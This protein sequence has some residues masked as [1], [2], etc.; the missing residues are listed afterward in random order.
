MKA[1]KVLLGAA[2]YLVAAQLLAGEAVFYITEEGSAVRD[3]AVSVN[4]QKKLVGAS[5]FVSFD[6]AAGNYRVELSKY[7]EYLGEFDFS[8]NSASEHA[9]IQVELVGGEPMPDINLY[10]P[11]QETAPAL[12][13]L[14]GFI[15]SAETGGGVAG[16]S[17]VVSGTETAVV[18]DSEGYFSLELPR[19]DYAL[20]IAHPNYGKRD[21][22]SV[23]VMGNVN[24]GL[25][26]TLSMSGDGM[27]EEVV[28]VGSYIPSTATAQQRDSS[29]VLN[30]IGAEQL[31]RFGDS[32]AASALK[33]VAG[34]S[35]VGGQFA[36]VRGM[37]GRYI[38]STLNG[39]LMPSTDPM[40]RDVPLD[41]F[42]AS[43][44]GGIE[45]Q[46][47]FTPDLPGDSTG[48]AIRM[49]TKDMPSESSGKVSVSLG[50]NDRTTFSDVN[51]YEGGGTD[52]LGIDDGTREQPGFAE[53]ITNGGLD[54]PRF[55]C[56]QSNCRP[57]DD[58]VKLGQSFE[59]I[60]NVDQVKAQPDRGF[61][62]ALSDYNEKSFGSTGSY[63]AL[64]YKDE[65]EARYE[66][67]LDDLGTVG[68]YDRSKRKIDLTGYF[69]YGVDMGSYLLESKSILLRK[70]DDTVRTE[71]VEDNGKDQELSST[72]LQ[73]VERQY[74]GQQFS[75]VHSLDLI[76]EDELSWR[77][78]FSQSSRYEPDRRSYQ[79][80]RSLNTTNP[81]RLLGSVERRYSDLTEN[82][83]DI[84]VDYV[85]D[86][87]VGAN[88]LKLKS[89]FM[90]NNKDREVDLAR[91]ANL[92]ISD[93]AIDT[94]LSLEEILSSD[95]IENGRAVILGTTTDT[96]DYEAKDTTMAFYLSGELDLG[97]VSVLAGA[98]AESFEQEISY[99]NQ[100]GSDTKLDES[101]L[102]PALSAVYRLAED[103]QIR[104][105]I[106]QTISKPGIT[107]RSESAQYDPETDDLLVG[108]PNLKISEIF[109]AD[110]RAEY[111]FSDD[112]SISLAYFYKDVTDPIERSVVEGDGSAADGYT[113]SNVPT[114]ILSGLELDFRVNTYS[115]DT[116]SSFL[117][118][119]VAWVDSEVDLTGTDAERLEGT[120]K[121]ALQGQSEYLA[122]L[123][124]GFDHLT[125]GQS[126]TFLVNYFDDRIY[127]TSR[128]QL[129]AEIEDAR[130]TVDLT[131]S[132]DVNERLSIKA[133]ASNIT[134]E[135][136]SYSRSGKEI[137]SYFEGGKYSASV[138]YVF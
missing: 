99:P 7:G 56:A 137:E 35:V 59:N 90:Y 20:A 113:F 124:I 114:A 69:V 11:G 121:R 112:E 118:G 84:G 108:N 127:A 33:R 102:L 106:S 74:L 32:S 88:L 72:I 132:Y 41:L 65:I 122:N 19:G 49:K 62:L 123:Q 77:I 38:S 47:T 60:Y 97:L 67:K 100:E 103:T 135:K 82:S 105:S 12:G 61:S 55:G 16:A 58:R 18:T 129:A 26:L 81:L 98:R 92:S 120:T 57:V 117:G 30:A 36:V 93:P 42:P 8:T 4:G 89:G 31:A 119:N 68:T 51:G 50:F 96:D 23:R 75:G 53:S 46:K 10:V 24:T 95:N 138:E 125:T 34:V 27:I 63:F 80:G 15:Q 104:A 111:Y 2:S 110:I 44:L 79:Y 39:S 101:V 6:I 94:S 37:Q 13:Q 87:L 131:Y 22:K 14:S 66:A 17:I 136:V 107:E 70:T 85:S 116:W 52:W 5:G 126:L 71:T 133:K 130:T 28:A 21:V 9:E 83:L 91:Y 134:D 1:T 128:G 29:S 78:G 64:Q 86:I 48:G 40:R 73:W 43:V 3:L 115:G 76:G 109:N 54:N 45:I 25:N